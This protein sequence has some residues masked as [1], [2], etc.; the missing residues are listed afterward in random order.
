MQ[1]APAP[2]PELKT[3]YAYLGNWPGYL[4]PKEAQFL[5]NYLQEL[6]PCKV[7]EIGPQGGRSTAFI[8]S[9]CKALG[10]EYFLL[11][12]WEAM[13]PINKMWL[14][15]AKKL[16]GITAEIHNN[17]TKADVAIVTSGRE[18]QID[19]WLKVAVPDDA[20]IVFLRADLEQALVSNLGLVGEEMNGG[21]VYKKPLSPKVD[22]EE[23][24]SVLP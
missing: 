22:T 14:E 11:D 5:Y 18:M 6:D 24:V 19:L 4:G 9:L 20:E 23:V 1:K 16:Y 7:L 13:H 21:M 2:L 8:G 3:L 12:D 17:A 15:R 10:H